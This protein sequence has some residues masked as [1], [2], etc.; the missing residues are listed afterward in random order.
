VT[1]SDG[2]NTT[3]VA[4]TLNEQDLNDAPTLAANT[5]LTVNEGLGATITSAELAVTDADNGPAQIV[6]TIT[7]APANGTVLLSGVPVGVGGTFT[8]DDI[9]N[10]RVTYV[11]DGSETV[12]DSFTFTVS[13]G[14]GGSIGP[15]V[16][17]VTI[18]AVNDAPVVNDQT[19]PNLAE[20]SANGTVVGNVAANDAEGDPLT[21]SIT[22][23][24]TGGA[25]AI[26]PLTGQVTV[27]NRAALD[28]ETTPV[29]TLTVQVDDGNGA[30][31]TAQV[32]INVTDVNETPVNTVPPG[33]LA[34]TEDTTLAIAGLS[35]TDPDGGTITVSLSV[36]NGVL[37]VNLSG[38]AFITGGANG[39]GALTLSGTVAQVNAALASLGYQGNPNF[40]GADTLTITSN[41]GALSDTDT[42]AINVAAVND[43]P[44]L[45]SN[46][47]TISAGSPLILSGANLS[48]SDVDNAA[49]GLV[50]SVGSISN[51][52][53]E[54]I[55]A[56][57]VAISSFTQADVLAGR[58]RFVPSGAAAPG[59]S[60]F[61]SD[62]SGG[63]IGPFA[64]NIT[65]NG[66]G[67]TPPPPP[68]GT[69]PSSSSTPPSPNPTAAVPPSN[70]SGPSFTAYLRGPTTPR[71]AGGEGEQKVES[72]TMQVAQ[73]PTQVL[74]TDRVFVPN[75]G[76]P[77]VR[78]QMDAL[79]TK[80]QRAEPQVEPGR[81]QVL[82]MGQKGLDLAEE[83]R[84]RIEVVLNSIRVTGFALS[85]GAVWWTARAVGLV[86]SLLSATPAWRHVDPLP[87]LLGR[88]EDEK[89]GWDDADE[90]D[91]EKKDDEHRAAWVLEERE[92]Q[93]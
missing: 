41:D 70:P 57:G 14:A 61:V 49:S 37:T 46:S 22:G 71:E 30:I 92:G 76:L 39:S 56:P 91:K 32:T 6:F 8:Q 67:F 64:A 58:V 89:E 87:A 84:Q 62:G 7:A 17:N 86:A 80:P 90:K 29:F 79:E 28:F 2:T 68:S 9:D 52:Y 48:A 1:A 54:L 82:P 31:D 59:F 63:N 11:H 60:I 5:G 81:L 40:N 83:D 19:L 42:L 55:S 74:K 27:A 12:A 77:A 45:D 25:F 73:P 18:N 24:N 88:D 72:L 51:G 21:Y 13:D 66:G 20:N 53:F 78:P 44:V 93:A 4:V 43:A 16:F 34:A 10:G 36:T 85:V 23:G 38:G 50:F 47:F 75:M 3:N 69:P 35:I 33:P 65:F 15:T 26:D